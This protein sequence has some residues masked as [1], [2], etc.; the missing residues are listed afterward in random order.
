M[1]LGEAF[2]VSSQKAY[3]ATA[4]LEKGKAQAGHFSGDCFTWAAKPKV[5]QSPNPY[6]CCPLRFPGAGL[7]V[8]ASRYV[9][10]IDKVP[11][12]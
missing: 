11:T 9:A 3:N 5:N 6:K 7:F 10:A 12:R 2:C 1:Q 4:G 8:I